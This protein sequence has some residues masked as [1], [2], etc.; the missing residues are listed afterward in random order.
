MNRQEMKNTEIR[1][2]EPVG[3]PRQ[4]GRKRPS[5]S[6]LRL[7]R[8]AMLLLAAMIFVVGLLLIVLPMFRVQR[9]EVE[10]CKMHTKEEIIDAL[11]ITEGQE[12]FAINPNKI[13]DSF[14]ET[15]AY[16]EDVTIVRSLSSVRIVIVERENVMYTQFNGRY[17]SFDRDFRVIEEVSDRTAFA[18]FLYV[19]LPEISKADAG[20]PIEFANETADPSYI[21]ELLEALEENGVLASVTELDCTRKYRV[22]YMMEALCRVELGKVNDMT[23]KLAVIEEI[24]A[25]KGGVGVAPAVIDVSDLQKPTYREL[26]AAELLEG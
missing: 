1:R 12:I 10:G 3:R 25:L 18:S 21:T 20:S 19:S 26:S 13:D 23:L 4:G 7:M 8:R 9:I 5:A 6:L 24:L 22:S 14:W 16:V 2:E 17:V 15:C 11:G